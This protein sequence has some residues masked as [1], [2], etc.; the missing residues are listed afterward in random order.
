[1]TV[2]IVNRFKAKTI[3]RRLRNSLNRKIVAHRWKKVF[4]QRTTKDIFTMI[5]QEELWKGSE[6]V[7]GYGSGIKYTENLQKTIIEIVNNFKIVSI[8]DLACGDFNWMRYVV[9]KIPSSYLG[10]D[11]VNSLIEKNKLK[12]ENDKVKFTTLDV[13]NDEIPSANLVICRDVL[14]HLPNEDILRIINK[15][16]DSPS[17]YLLI[18]N[19]IAME[20]DSFENIDISTGDFRRIDLFK[21]PFNLPKSFILNIDDWL[22]PDPPRTMILFVV[23]QLRKEWKIVK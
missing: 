20:T 16:V 19:H 12:Y 17:K 11:I 7:S 2:F 9:D 5:Y 8:L 1:M 4:A 10:V 15:I 6:S 3:I 18:T 14:F 23:D 22:Y 13:V 21:P